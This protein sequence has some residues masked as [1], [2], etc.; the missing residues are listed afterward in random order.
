MLDL[1][2]LAKAINA[3]TT[4]KNRLPFIAPNY[5]LIIC[6]RMQIEAQESLFDPVIGM[7]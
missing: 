5:T 2:C 6:S 7:K 3:I 4:I 1:F